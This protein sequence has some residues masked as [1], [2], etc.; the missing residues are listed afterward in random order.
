MS[1]TSH[2]ISMKPP[3]A[4]FH[5]FGPKTAITVEVTVL[6]NRWARFWFRFFF[7][8]KFQ[9]TPIPNDP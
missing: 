2:F 5:P 6:P 4:Y 7:N 3:A 1:V 9:A 8:W